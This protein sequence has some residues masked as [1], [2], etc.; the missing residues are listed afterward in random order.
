MF[1]LFLILCLLD[2]RG[3]TCTMVQSPVVGSEARC[4]D[5]G[6]ASAQKMVAT[7]R[8]RRVAGSVRAVCRL[9]SENL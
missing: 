7:L 9:K 8:Q 3:K 2:D 6:K 1:E 5:A 4:R